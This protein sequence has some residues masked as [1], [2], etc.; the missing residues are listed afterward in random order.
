[1]NMND[2]LSFSRSTKSIG[3]GNINT[4]IDSLP[5][6]NIDRSNISPDNNS[7]FLLNNNSP[8][9][10][11]NITISKINSKEQ[12]SFIRGKKIKNTHISPLPSMQS[13]TPL[14]Q[15]S[16]LSPFQAQKTNSNLLNVN[17][18]FH[19][20]QNN[21]LG[22]NLNRSR[23][24]MADN[25]VKQLSRRSFVDPGGN[26]ALYQQS[27]ETANLKLVEKELQFKLLDMSMQIENNK[28]SDDEESNT[29]S[30]LNN[31]DKQDKIWHKNV[32]NE[33]ESYKKEFS[34]KDLRRKSVNVNEVNQ[35]Y[36][37]NS[38]YNLGKGVKRGNKTIVKGSMVHKMGTN[39][40]NLNTSSFRNDLSKTNINMNMNKG[41]RRSLNKYT[42]Y[43]INWANNN[44][45][46]NKGN[47]SMYINLKKNMSINRN[48]SFNNKTVFVNKNNISMNKFMSISEKNKEYENKYRTIKRNKEL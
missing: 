6:I 43:G 41:R 34:F 24:S 22:N 20:K 9:T 25:I 1:M 29:F 11:P 31:I 15:L 8:P 10:I 35:I 36:N 18:L 5:K 44:M 7:N 40:N 3:S 32:K 37:L 13:L 46:I 2:L 19:S 45:S 42:T 16:S 39:N 48:V 26:N 23:L 27:G 12:S 14:C 33:L 17:Y 21:N 30:G 47:K 28:N 4:K 38:F